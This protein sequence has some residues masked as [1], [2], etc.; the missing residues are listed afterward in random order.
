MTQPE[1]LLINLFYGII[2]SIVG[3]LLFSIGVI[4]QKKAVADMP[5]I[6]LNNV[7]SMLEM[8]R[9]RTWLI[10]TGI[11][12]LGGIPYIITQ[13]LVGVAL[14]QPLIL[15]IQLIFIVLLAIK[16][17]DE[18]LQPLEI[19]GFLLLISS[20]ILLV[21]GAVT[22]P[23]VD[24]R[25][26][27][28]LLTSSLFL[29][30][31]SIL[32]VIFFFIIKFKRLNENIIGISYA[33]I[34]GIFFAMGAIFMQVGVEVI[35]GQYADLLFIGIVFILIMFLGNVMGTLLQ[36]LAFQ[37]GKVG[38]SIAVQSTC[39]LLLAIYGGILIFSQQILFPIFYIA[40]IIVILVSNVILIQFQARLEDT[41]KQETIESTA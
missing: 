13:A 27:T 15:G 18:K 20:P 38:I 7:D 40:G 33:I 31:I 30:L 22:P 36:N 3:A 35:K 41:D 10:G 28:F 29:I 2:T 23:N 25:S 21:L 6:K 39:N 5:E 1:L 26:Q 12:L 37:R 9:N 17:L 34:S 32:L 4:L 11:A 19:F 24:L 8:V 16:M 14:T